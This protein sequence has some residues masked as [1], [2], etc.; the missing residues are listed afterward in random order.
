MPSQGG[1]TTGGRWVR[2]AT[3][4]HGMII[5]MLRSFLLKPEVRLNP[6]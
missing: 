1:V 5:K 6:A 3:S 2:L 4:K